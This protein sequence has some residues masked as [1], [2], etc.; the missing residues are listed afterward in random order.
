MKNQIDM[1][2]FEKIIG[3]IILS[4]FILKLA[5]V[6]GASTFL[7]FFFIF[8]ILSYTFFG[9]VILNQIHIK[10]LFKKESFRDISA[11]RLVG[12]IL[13]GCVFAIFCMG[14]LFKIQHWPG[15]MALPYIA[16]ILAII[17][18]VL[19]LL[20]YFKT[21]NIFYLNTLKRF[22]IIS[23][24]SL[25]FFTIPEL[26]FIKIEFR[27]HPGYIKAFEEY[28]KKP[29]DKETHKVLEYEY[30]KAVLSKD[31]FKKFEEYTKSNK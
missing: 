13:L 23:C 7:V 21:K 6:P 5:L 16:F 26:T 24:F 12:T 29:F 28:Q 8:L 18:L 14:C 19:I 2:K 3:V 11:L 17:P 9:F 22:V 27:N 4:T 25:I 10:N 20:K 31:D 1:S 15:A 30:N